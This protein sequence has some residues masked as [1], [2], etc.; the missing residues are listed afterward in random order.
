MD[1]L[2]IKSKLLT[3]MVSKIIRSTVKKKLG[4]DIDIHL[5][6]LTATINDGKAHI[7][8]NAEGNVD[9]KEFKKFTKVIGLED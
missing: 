3:N 2:K 6:E 5:Y 7:Y 8:I 1:E 4:Y 9:V